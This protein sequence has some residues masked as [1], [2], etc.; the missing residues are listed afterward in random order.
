MRSTS[1]RDGTDLP[2]HRIDWF[3]FIYF[4]ITRKSSFLRRL[5]GTNAYIQALTKSEKKVTYTLKS[6]TC[7]QIPKYLSTDATDCCL[8]TERSFDPAVPENRMSRIQPSPSI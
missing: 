5:P 1:T 6:V 7:Q 4:P 8:E 2:E 3:V